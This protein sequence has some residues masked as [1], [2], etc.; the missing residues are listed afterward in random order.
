LAI[1]EKLRQYKANKARI[2]V[3][4]VQIKQIYEHISDLNGEPVEEQIEGKLFSIPLS[5]PVQGGNMRDPTSMIAFSGNH[6]EIR[7]AYER[8]DLLQRERT[9][10]Q[11]LVDEIDAAL[12]VL[13]EPELFIIEQYYIQ[14]FSWQQVLAHWLNRKGVDMSERWAKNQREFALVKICET[15][16]SA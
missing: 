16:K 15:I 13:S 8:I 5:D 11:Y 7:E 14:G 4:D 2:A 10:L 3:L 1:I 6:I 12:S 9:D